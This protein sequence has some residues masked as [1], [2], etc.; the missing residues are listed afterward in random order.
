VTG[1]GDATAPQIIALYSKRWRVEPSFRDTKDLRF[2]LSTVRIGDPQR[3]CCC[4]MPSPS[5]CSPGSAPPAR[6]S[7]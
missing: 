4:S 5:S 7:A 2:G 6:A 1:T 3:R